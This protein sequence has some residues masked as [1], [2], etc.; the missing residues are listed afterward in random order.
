MGVQLVSLGV[1]A[2]LGSFSQAHPRQD[3]EST[4]PEK[5]SQVRSALGDATGLPAAGRGRY[6]LSC[7]TDFRSR[8]R[9][10]IRISVWISRLNKE[11]KGT[12]CRD[13]GVGKL[14]CTRPVKRHVCVVHH[15]PVAG[16]C[17]RNAAPS[18]SCSF[19]ASGETRCQ[20]TGSG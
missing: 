19:R 7:P 15:P 14:K 12:A 18:L 10:G 5:V 1:P 3:T 8:H 9:T 16:R 4:A 6:W 20:A 17:L 2:F 13:Y 11:V